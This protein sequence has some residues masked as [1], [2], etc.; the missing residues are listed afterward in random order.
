MQRGLSPSP[1]TQ[2]NKNLVGTLT[3]NSRGKLYQAHVANNGLI[4]FV[5]KKRQTMQFFK[6]AK[7]TDKTVHR[8]EN[9]DF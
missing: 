9:A 8:R 2:G 6:R 7:G 5:H 3:N 1:R 4:S